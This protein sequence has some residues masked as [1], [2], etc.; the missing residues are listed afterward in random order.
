MRRQKNDLRKISF[1]GQYIC[2]E[3]AVVRSF[4]L[5]TDDGDPGG[6]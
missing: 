4:G 6:G 1:A 3:A 2:D 5:L